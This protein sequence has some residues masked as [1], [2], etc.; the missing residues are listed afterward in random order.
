MLGQGYLS[1][2]TVIIKGTQVYNSEKGR[3]TETDALDVMQM[4]GRAGLPYKY[5]PRVQG[6]LITDH[7]QLE[8][9]L[10]LMNQQVSQHLNLEIIQISF[11]IIILAPN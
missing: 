8:Y 9:Y 2:H 4:I 10:S 6:I 3:W 7:C 11:F 1:I 5:D